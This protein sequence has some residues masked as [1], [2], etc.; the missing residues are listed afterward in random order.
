MS[1]ELGPAL[2]DEGVEAVD[3]DLVCESFGLFHTKDVA[4]GVDE[5]VFLAGRHDRGSLPRRVGGG[6]E[7]DGSP[8]PRGQV[9]GQV[10]GR[11][12]ERSC[13][14]F[15]MAGEVGG[16]DILGKELGQPP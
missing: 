9:R 2:G 10:K 8:Q 3:Y 7:R 15:R 6:E 1:A 5:A 4:E 13:A 11:E 12:G 16:A 14:A